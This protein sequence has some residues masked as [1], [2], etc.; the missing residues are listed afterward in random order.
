MA[1]NALRGEDE[2]QGMGCRV[3]CRR[4]AV[5]GWALVANRSDVDGR[6]RVDHVQR[7]SDLK[8]IVLHFAL[9]DERDQCDEK[10]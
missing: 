3:K 6:R 1:R 2:Q 9:R 4:Q 5:A 7:G 8:E 10:R